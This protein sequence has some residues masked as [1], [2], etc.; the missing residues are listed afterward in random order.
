MLKA[1]LQKAH[2][3][4]ATRVCAVHGWVA[5]TERLDPRAIAFHFEAQAQGTLAEGARLELDVRWVE[6][7]CNDCGQNYKP[8]HHLLLCP[9]CGS[10][11]AALLGDTG[12]GVDTIEV[13]GA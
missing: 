9:E 7:H 4:G 8:D 3:V 13:D 2:E 1:V 5:E 6:A 11:E 10:T 12:L